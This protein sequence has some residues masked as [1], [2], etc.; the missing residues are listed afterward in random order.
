MLKNTGSPV[1]IQ[2]TFRTGKSARS[3]PVTEED[4]RFIADIFLLTMP[5]LCCMSVTWMEGSVISGNRVC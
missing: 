1:G 3:A 4:Q 5:N 2:I